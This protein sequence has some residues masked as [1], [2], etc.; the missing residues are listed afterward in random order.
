[1]AKRRT[2]DA[3]EAGPAGGQP[4]AVE[5]EVA[6]GDEL[7]FLDWSYRLLKLERIQAEAE[8]ED[9]QDIFA[10]TFQVDGPNANAEVEIIVSD[11]IDEALVVSIAQHTL[12]VA[13]T[14]W[15]RVTADRLIGARAN[16][17]PD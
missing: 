4:Q 1:M 14:M 5:P 12:H 11:F 17:L 7:T 8:D 2:G 15:G 13:A 3:V 10:A 9:G 6:D 16:D